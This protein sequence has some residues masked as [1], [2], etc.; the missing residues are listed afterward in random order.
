[1]STES[2]S[3]AVHAQPAPT[4]PESEAPS[5]AT[6]RR[7]VALPQAAPNGANQPISPYL[8]LLIESPTGRSVRVDT[9]VH[10]CVLDL[11]Q[12]LLE[13]PE[14]CE[15]TCYHLFHPNTQTVLNDYV[16]L[17]EYPQLYNESSQLLRIMPEFYDERA[18]RIHVRR[19]R[20]LLVNPP[21]H[22]VSSFIPMIDHLA[23]INKKSKRSKGNKGN[24]DLSLTAT[25]LS[26][27]KEDEFAINEYFDELWKVG[28]SHKREPIIN[29]CVRNIN[30]SAWNP[31]P[32]NRKLRGD[33]LYLEINTIE[34]N[35]LHVTSCVDGYYLNQS[36]ST[37]FN[38]NPAE[39]SYKSHSLVDLLKRASPIF[40][41]KFTAALGRKISQHPFEAADLP[42]KA[43][44]WLGQS[45][46]HTYDWNRSEDALLSTY[47]MDQRGIMRDWNEEYQSCKDLPKQTLNDRIMRDRTVYRVYCDFVEA[48]TKG[49]CAVIHG[50]IPPVNPMEAPKQ[51]VFIYNN[52][53][54]SFAVDGRDL[55]TEAGGDR[56]SYAQAM[57]DLKGV[58][59]IALLDLND[60]YTL[61]TVII[62]YR[63]HRVIAQSII[64][65]IFHGDRASKHVYGSTDNG[66]TI[67]AKPEFHSI[68]LQAAEK[69]HLAPHTVADK[70]GKQWSLASSFE[71]KGIV[72]SDGRNYILDLLRVQPRD[73]NY[74]DP[75]RHSTSLLRPELVT[76]Y[77]R[78]LAVDKL[79]PNNKAPEENKENSE[80][81]QDSPYIKFLRE[82]RF[83][84]DVLTK[85]RLADPESKQKEDEAAVFAM[86]K[87]LL[88]EQIPNFVKG[89]KTLEYSPVDC[90]SL[91]K[92]LHEHGINSRYLGKVLE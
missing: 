4:H 92:L 16:E 26:H 79:F 42:R 8:S 20:E 87:F 75:V 15:F 59:Q 37:T 51:H 77:C 60:L 35:T 19:L 88:E 28:G 50:H 30:F 7:A 53:F 22:V 31:P 43:T 52:I 10:D 86:A 62:D 90:A 74:P 32:G 89:L 55:Y 44:P 76:L 11:K 66:D 48:A 36:T 54:F 67:E 65:G 21:A 1:M 45:T 14:T 85:A 82:L 13:C 73:A 57:N 38:P 49:A 78:K 83:N 64:P 29:E 71:S 27:R 47:G 25:Q 41:A 34:N 17:I 63:G 24:A 84:P 69:L 40:N 46:Q 3:P 81:S 9:S 72:G 80:N 18:S 6:A 12:F 58:Q 91:T 61:A 68:M 5:R 70:Q 56:V 23:E 2:K 39:T 33:L